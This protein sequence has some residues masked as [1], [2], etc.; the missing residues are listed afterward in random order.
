MNSLC[1][2]KVS[3]I[4]VRIAQGQ[5]TE[6]IWNQTVMKLNGHVTCKLDHKQGVPA[7]QLIGASSYYPFTKAE[8]FIH[9]LPNWGTIMNDQFTNNECSWLCTMNT[10]AEDRR[11]TYRY[12]QYLCSLS[13][14]QPQQL[15]RPTVG[16]S[17]RQA[18]RVVQGKGTLLGWCRECGGGNHATWQNAAVDSPASSGSSTIQKNQDR[19]LGL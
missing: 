9:K 15:F 19:P 7:L 4:H 12:I 13:V 11:S 1:F 18:C 17:C 16:E 5:S 8:K 10:N 14:H 3:R 2:L 6:N